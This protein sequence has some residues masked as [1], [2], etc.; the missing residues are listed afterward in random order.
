MQLLYTRYILFLDEKT[1]PISLNELTTL[2]YSVSL[3]NYKFV[4]A[5]ISE[6]YKELDIVRGVAAWLRAVEG[7]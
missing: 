3:S 6:H 5:S 4:G 1:W 2:T 7:C